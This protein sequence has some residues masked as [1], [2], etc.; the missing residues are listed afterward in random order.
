MQI[1]RAGGPFAPGMMPLIGELIG[2]MKKTFRAAIIGDTEVSFN[3]VQDILL[4]IKY[5]KPLDQLTEEELRDYEELKSLFPKESFEKTDAQALMTPERFADLRKGYGRGLK[6][7]TLMKPVYFGYRT[8]EVDGKQE[9]IPTYLKNSTIVITDDLAIRFPE[10]GRIRAQMRNNKIDELHFG[11][12]TKLGRPKQLTS[13]DSF[14][15]PEV[16]SNNNVLTLDNANYRIQLNPRSKVDKQVS[17]PT[18]LMYFIN[19]LNK[20][21]KESREIYGMLSLILEDGLMDF[22]DKSK[23]FRR[24]LSSKFNNSTDFRFFDILAEGISHQ[25]PLIEKKAIIQL[26]SLLEKMTVGLKFPG[27]KTNVQ[28]AIGSDVVIDPSTGEML[29]DKPLEYF[30]DRK[31]GNALHS[32]AIIPKGLLP[33]WQE[34]KVLAGEPIYVNGDVL[35]FRIPSTELHSALSIKVVGVY[36]SKGTNSIIVPQLVMAISGHDHDGDSIFLIKRPQYKKDIKFLTSDS[37]KFATSPFII[38]GAKGDII[39]FNKDGTKTKGFEQK[40]IDQIKLHKKIISNTNIDKFF[41]DDVRRNLNDLKKIRKDFYLGRIVDTM[42]D[43]VASPQNHNRVLAPINKGI[44]DPIIEEVQEAS[45]ELPQ[46]VDLA[47]PLGARQALKN[48]ADGSILI[49][50][51]ANA[52]KDVAYMIKSGVTTEANSSVKKI[53]EIANNVVDL[54]EATD[55]IET[56]KA[57]D[58]EE[59]K[60][61]D[62]AKS[63]PTEP[64]ISTEFDPIRLNIGTT[65]GMDENGNEYPIPVISTF[66]KINQE[67]AGSGDNVWNTLASMV[68]IA[69]DNAKDQILVKIN[70]TINTGPAYMAL[71]SL[72]YPKQTAVY[73]MTQPVIKKIL[74]GK[75]KLSTTKMIS[76]IGT[77][78]ESIRKTLKDMGVDN[79]NDRREDHIL[80]DDKLLSLFSESPKRP[81]GELTE[82]EEALY[83]KNEISR[84]LYTEQVLLTFKTSVKLGDALTKM[85]RF[86]GIV[87]SQ[88]VVVE[89]LES[90]LANFSEIFGIHESHFDYEVTPD[91]TLEEYLEAQE[92]RKLLANT[93]DFAYNIPLFFHQN[94][95]I[96]S[97]IRATLALKKKLEQHFDIHTEEF[98]SYMDSLKLPQVSLDGNKTEVGLRREVVKYLMSRIF[99]DEI[100][101]ATA[102]VKTLKGKSIEVSGSK[103]WSENWIKRLEAVM[104]FDRLKQ[105]DDYA[106]NHF[107]NNMFVKKSGAFSV[108]SFSNASNLVAEDFIEFEKAFKDL[109]RYDVSEVDGKL[110]VKEVA[111]NPDAYTDFQKEFVTYAA[112][113]FGFNFATS[114]FA[115]VLPI[116]LYADFSKQ[117]DAEIKN[118]AGKDSTLRDMARDHLKLNLMIENVKGVRS[119]VQSESKAIK[120]GN[121]NKSMAIVTME[122]KD[123]PVYSDLSYPNEYKDKDSDTG[124]E[125]EFPY[126]I[127]RSETLYRRISESSDKLVNY[128][129]LGKTDDYGYDAFDSDTDYSM[130]DRFDPRILTLTVASTNTNQVSSIRDLSKEL[131]NGTIIRIVSKFDR[132]RQFPVTVRLVEEES[133][134]GDFFNYT[135]TPVENIPLTQI[136]HLKQ[137]SDYFQIKDSNGTHYL[138]VVGDVIRTASTQL[139]RFEGK[140]INDMRNY[141][142]L[143]KG[144]IELLEK[145]CS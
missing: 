76:A 81:E 10:L 54:D 46:P 29:R 72:G 16:D 31:N 23:N 25:N 133:K 82:Q 107:L 78:L 32:E 69:I 130:A 68:N 100:R 4:K 27:G 113:R 132:S 75:G 128:Q 59:A 105:D 22:G 44:W 143:N 48:V 139:K 86:L 91:S 142:D 118:F 145:D 12:G 127:V 28:S 125:E 34:K 90:I 87:R 140:K 135:I 88:P 1:K 79:L 126:Y 51:D 33:E 110:V 8:E 11:S 36:D 119:F 13:L 62:E 89:D 124:F 56:E 116:D 131:E 7:S 121:T 5:N 17:I 129:A 60:V 71:L 9:S 61:F 50:V 96:A 47:S 115:A 108:V 114:N 35:G 80:S 24:F 70:A 52:I 42:L 49:G 122:G 104:N 94:P 120:Y 2:G 138:E 43:L 117:L 63:N 99:K 109:N 102:S 64:S 123:T 98:K 141:L 144:S 18:Q 77:E 45:G 106:G 37:S 103:A 112:L 40:I 74:D 38:G 58:I 101:G 41:R 65:Y 26:G 39:G 134:D 111:Y 84:L 30:I 55:P 92:G 97:S 15:D 66:D 93:E 19:V 21:P 83:R 53:F 136:S 67:E 57:I 6:L 3:S 20:N 85:S 137:E 14:M 95:H 73:L